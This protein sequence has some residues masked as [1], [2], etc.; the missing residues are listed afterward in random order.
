MTD[1]VG[2][3]FNFSWKWN[4]AI[5]IQNFLGRNSIAFCWICRKLSNDKRRKIWPAPCVWSTKGNFSAKKWDSSI[6]KTNDSYV[7]KWWTKYQLFLL[8]HPKIQ[9]YRDSVLSVH[10][11]AATQKCISIDEIDD[12]IGIWP[13]LLQDR[14]NAFCWCGSIGCLVAQFNA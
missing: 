5:V 12:F 7:T 4:K 6:R 3:F 14:I 2:F 13:A 8:L 1:S 10:A 9:A 11:F